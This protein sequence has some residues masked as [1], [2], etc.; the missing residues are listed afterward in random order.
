MPEITDLRLDLRRTMESLPP[1]LKAVSEL[2][3]VR[4]FT[5]KEISRILG[6]GLPLVKYRM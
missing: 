4:G 1:E 5:Q 6:I 2:V 3:M